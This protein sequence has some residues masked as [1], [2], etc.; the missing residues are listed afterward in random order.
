MSSSSSR[1]GFK[2]G[3]TWVRPVVVGLVIFVLIFV[4]YQVNFFGLLG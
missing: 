3:K 2:G 1:R 4:L